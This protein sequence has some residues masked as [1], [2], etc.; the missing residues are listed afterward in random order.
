MGR[1]VMEETWARRRTRPSVNSFTSTVSRESSTASPQPHSTSESN[2]RP[3]HSV[4]QPHRVIDGLATA[5]LNLINRV[6]KVIDG[7][8]TASLN[9]KYRCLGP[10]GAKA[11]AAAL[12]V[13]GSIITSVQSNLTIGR[14]AVAHILYMYYSRGDGEWTRP[15]RSLG[16]RCCVLSCILTGAKN[17][18]GLCRW[19]RA[20]CG[21]YGPVFEKTCA[22]TQKNVKKIIF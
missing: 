11:L 22:A 18:R 19:R 2:R 1:H 20:R 6:Q 9:L 16:S 5:S 7:L 4:T 17:G 14:S 15:P 3:R 21:A 10:L 8:A 12:S 13:S